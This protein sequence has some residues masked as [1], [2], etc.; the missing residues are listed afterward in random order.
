MKIKQLKE[1]SGWT[2]N[3]SLSFAIKEKEGWI[4][5]WY[6]YDNQ[7]VLSSVHVERVHRFNFT[8]GENNE[9][10]DSIPF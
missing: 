9:N 5:R 1:N 7:L 3:A 4:I 10:N 6:N 2:V 8:Y